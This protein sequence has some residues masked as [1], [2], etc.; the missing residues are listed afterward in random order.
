M[1]TPEQR[2]L[3]VEIY[4]PTAR[5]FH[6]WTVAFVAIM[7]P[8]GFAMAYRGGTLNIWD[9]TTNN[10]YSAHKLLGFIVL[11]FSVARL[12]NRLRNGAPADEPTL[13]WWQ[14]AASHLTHWAIYG[15]LILV[16]LLGWLGVSMYGARDLFGL[17]SLPPLAPTDQKRGEFILYLHGWA[18][19]G[20]LLL[21]ANHFAAAMFHFLIRKDGVLSR[22]LPGVGNRR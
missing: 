7:F 8:L 18:A 4:S 2:A 3:P 6:W 16:P 17:V 22:M 13:E 1:P 14:K 11:W 9:A 15:F 12:V 20:L 21:I 19:I 5:K 10:M